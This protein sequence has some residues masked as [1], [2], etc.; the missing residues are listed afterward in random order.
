LY[1]DSVNLLTSLCISL[2]IAL[3]SASSPTGVDV[4]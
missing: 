2:I 3:A 1:A 4:A